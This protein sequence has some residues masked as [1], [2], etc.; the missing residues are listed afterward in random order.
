M[1][2]DEYQGKTIFVTGAASG[3]GQAQA[4]SFVKQG[5][6]VLGMDLDQMGL[7]QTAEHVKTASGKFIACTGDVTKEDQISIAVKKANES[8][9]TI[10]IL[11]NTAGILDDYTPTLETTEALW[12]RVLGI[13]LKGT[14]LITNQILPQ[15][16]AQ[17][18]GVIIN[19]AS[20]AGMVAGG[21]GA[22]YTASKH[23]IIGYTKQLDH[24]Y[25]RKGIRANAIAPGAIQTPM[26]AAD[27]AGDGTMAKWVANETPAG[28]W[29]KPEEVASLTLFLASEQADYIH[30]TVM[31]IDG[32]WLEK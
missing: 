24:D 26:N 29:A 3:I 32:G 8:F 23:A 10:Q 2:F 17:K 6:N 11:L 13:N 9:G 4:I 12:D 1:H 30:G 5:A 27:F 28:R 22:A 15:M 21:G 16:I 18:Q 20:I 25:I 7:S 14:F 19:M 31:T